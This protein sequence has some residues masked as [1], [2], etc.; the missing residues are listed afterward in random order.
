MLTHAL[1]SVTTTQFFNLIKA[2]IDKVVD[3]NDQTVAFDVKRTFQCDVRQI[4]CV[5]REF[6][7]DDPNCYNIR[8]GFNVT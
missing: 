4:C 1:R 5:N 6:L 7:L 3:V 2:Q 8:F